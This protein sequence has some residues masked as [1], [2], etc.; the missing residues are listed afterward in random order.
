MKDFLK[1]PTLYIIIIIILVIL[2][3]LK[4]C[5]PGGTGLFGGKDTVS[6][7]QDTNKKGKDNFFRPK[8]TILRTSKKSVTDRPQK[9]TDKDLNTVS[10]YGAGVFLTAGDNGKAFITGNGGLNWDTLNTGVTDTLN[11]SA[12]LNY[13][14]MLL[15]GNNGKILRSVDMGRNWNIM[16][17]TTTKD[18]NSLSFA[19]TMNGYAVGKKGTVIKTADGGVTWSSVNTGDTISLNTVNVYRNTIWIAGNSGTLYKS[20]SGGANW[21]K[22]TL[23]PAVN[24]YGISFDSLNYGIAVGDAGKIFTTTNGGTAW[25]V[26]TTSKPN[27]L[28]GIH[29]V[30]PKLSYIAGDGLLVRIDNGVP[31][32]LPVDTTKKYKAVDPSPY[33][34]GIFSGSAGIVGDV[35]VGACDNCVVKHD[36]VFY[37]I[38]DTT[39]RVTLRVDATSAFGHTLRIVVPGFQLDHSILSGWTEMDNIQ[40]NGNPRIDINRNRNVLLGN[41][42]SLA[43]DVTLPDY[44]DVDMD[45]YLEDNNITS[46]RRPSTIQL[47]Y[48]ITLNPLNATYHHDENT[49]SYS[50]Q[51][52]YYFTNT[53]FEQNAVLGGDFCHYVTYE[54][55]VPQN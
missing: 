7:K 3:L 29:V 50:G 53:D 15:A 51:F 28:F 13:Y 33:L 39:W 46:T 21:T 12:V 25:T 54:I 10:R 42:T 35:T 47:N 16:P 30:S 32:Y 49:I 11:G 26:S 41:N 40:G 36:L 1:K 22:T 37:Q 23:S 27:K 5:G 2:L 38:S 34:G 18:L 9:L 17:S 4:S 55:I 45:R 20:T 48:T 24:L 8:K 14:K 52:Q 19:D 43:P 44:A 31:N 6:T